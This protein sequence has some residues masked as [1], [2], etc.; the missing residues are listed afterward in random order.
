[1]MSKRY[2]HV[3]IAELS[4]NGM[5]A[6]QIAEQ[7]GCN[8]RT[9]IRVSKTQGITAPSSN[10]FV[11]KPISADRLTAA[12]ELLDDGAPHAEVAAALR[13]NRRTLQ[14]HF[15]GTQWTKEQKASHLAAIRSARKAGV[16]L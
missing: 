5:S 6:S 11:S 14:K 4:L 2:D 9:V 7:V 15:P 3:L 10:E 12:K 16:F 1:M 8:R 13:I